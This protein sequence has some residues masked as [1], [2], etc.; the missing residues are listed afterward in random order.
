[1]D[2]ESTQNFLNMPGSITPSGFFG[3]GK[4]NIFEVPEIVSKKEQDLLLNFIKNNKDW[5]NYKD[6]ID[7]DGLVLYQNDPWRDR[8]CTSNTLQ[9]VNIEVHDTI[10]IIIHRLKLIVE[11]K[12]N[13]IA[14]DTGA[15]MVRWP[16]GAR[17]EPHADKEFWIGSEAGRPNSFPFY[18]LGSLFY[19][20]SDYEGGELYFPQHGIEF[21]PNERSAYV[22]I[23]DRYYAHGVRPVKSGMRYTCPLFWT[24]KE[25][26]GN[27]KPMEGFRGGFESEFYAK[28]IN[29]GDKY[30]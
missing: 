20:N 14:E 6:S 4:E 8:V 23:G 29:N 21:K 26:T 25:H 11:S 19:L 13:I 12:F 18:D 9:R 30:D 15:A 16:V 10:R 7:K 5:D 2:I 28:Q 3:T 22:F 24:I 17:Q 27:K 1:M